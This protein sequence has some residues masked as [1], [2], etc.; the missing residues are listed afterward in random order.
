[1]PIPISFTINGVSR[2]VEV[3]DARVTLLDLLRER[4]DLTGH[5]EGLRPR[6]VRRLHGAARR[7]AGQCLPGARGQP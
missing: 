1:M 7:P 6:A 4:L 5:Q 2:H 3:E